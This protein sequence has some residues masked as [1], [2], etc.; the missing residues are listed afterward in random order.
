MHLISATY[1][2]EYPGVRASVKNVKILNRGQAYTN[3][4]GSAVCI[5]LCQMFLRAVEQPYSIPQIKK[6]RERNYNKIQRQK[7]ENVLIVVLLAILQQ[8][9][10]VFHELAYE[11]LQVEPEKWADK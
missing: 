5:C 2:Y 3:C 4:A 1:V 7:Q 6:R 8:S 10:K 11:S 9:H